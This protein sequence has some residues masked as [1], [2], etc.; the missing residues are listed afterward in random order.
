[1]EEEIRLWDRRFDRIEKR[2]R[3][4]AGIRLTEWP[5]W[6]SVRHAQELRNA[7]THNLGMYTSAYLTTKLAYRPTEDDLHG[8]GPVDSDDRLINRELIPLSAK[9]VDQVIIQL[10][11][12][13][14]EVREAIESL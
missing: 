1:V 14:G 3:D 12:V 7:L 2:Y 8:F 11:E 6:D 13:S 5:S 4:F 9:F 10:I